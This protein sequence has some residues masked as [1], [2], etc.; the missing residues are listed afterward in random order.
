MQHHYKLRAACASWLMAALASACNNDASIGRD[1][2]VG[3]SRCSAPTPIPRAYDA[4]ETEVDLG[5]LDT[6]APSERRTLRTGFDGIYQVLLRDGHGAFWDGR[7]DAETRE[8]VLRRHADDGTLESEVRH[9][10]PVA[11]TPVDAGAPQLN[12]LTGLDGVL[13]TPGFLTVSVPDGC[14]PLEAGR[15]G[16]TCPSQHY[17]VLLDPTD[18]RATPS[19]W[20]S[21]VDIYTPTGAIT[22]CGEGAMPGLWRIDERDVTCTDTH[23]T[24]VLRQT[25]VAELTRSFDT[26]ES[27]WSSVVA[28]PGGGVVATWS[29]R[30]TRRGAWSAMLALDAAGEPQRLLTDDALDPSKPNVSQFV[31][32]DDRLVYAQRS[33]S[34]DAV[35]A[36]IALADG[37]LHGQYRLKRAGYFEVLPQFAT[38]DDGDAYFT[39]LTGLREQAQRVLCKLPRGEAVVCYEI[40]AAGMAGAGT[41]YPDDDGV[42]VALPAEDESRDTRLERYDF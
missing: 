22:P 16:V 20:P 7:A 38:A 1:R 23:G 35:I 29:G 18:F 2:C 19:W 37:S 31:D 21:Q 28:R 17:P 9:A 11:A 33:L 15:Q 39:L 25:A 36:R 8:F 30:D 24:L 42:F 14:R 32:P 10:I 3:V 41:P 6:L 34:S 13:Q 27:T 26:P 4:P 40:G 5:S 12:D